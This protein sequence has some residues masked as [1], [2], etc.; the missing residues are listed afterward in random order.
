MGEGQFRFENHYRDPAT[1]RAFASYDQYVYTP[2]YSSGMALLGVVLL[3]YSFV[4]IYIDISVLFSICGYTG[5]QH[6]PTAVC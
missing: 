4:F 6:W 2:Q 5:E 3:V 1:K